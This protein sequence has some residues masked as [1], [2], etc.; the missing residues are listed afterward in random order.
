MKT[1]LV[2][3][4]GWVFFDSPFNMKALSGT[5][6]AI[7]GIVAY[8]LQKMEE[9]KGTKG[10]D[11]ERE[12]STSPVVRG[13]AGVGEARL[14]HPV[15]RDCIPPLL[16]LTWQ[17]LLLAALPEAGVAVVGAVA[18]GALCGASRV[19]RAGRKRCSIQVN[20]INVVSLHESYFIYCIYHYVFLISMYYGW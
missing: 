17:F 20:L 10:R 5:A 14:A 7:V 19:G 15:M 18:G 6:I 11:K 1:V 9:E 12:L 8:G 2:L 3:T 4:M 16:R 13:G